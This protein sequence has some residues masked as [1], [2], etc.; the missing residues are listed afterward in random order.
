MFELV[1]S[2]GWLMLPIIACSIVALGIVFERLWSLQ[3]KKVMPDYLMRQILQLHR[4]KKLDLADLNKLRTSSPLGRILAAGLINRDHNKEVM[5][6]AIEEVGRQVVHELER[7]LNTLGT[8]ASISP[9]LGL[10]GTVIGMIKVFSVIV[11]A[12]V[13][14]PGVLAGGISEALITT[15][16]GLSVAIPSLMFHRYFS[17]LIDRLVMG[18]EEQALKLVEVIHGERELR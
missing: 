6:E 18:M 3:R 9:L 11:T 15:A 7:Y 12:G 16:A 17:G 4:D 14:D 8:I 1:K 10:L 13:G 2:G 5:K